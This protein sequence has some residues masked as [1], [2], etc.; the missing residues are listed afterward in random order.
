MGVWEVL[1][2]KRKGVESLYLVLG[3]E[4]RTSIGVWYGV[5]TYNMQYHKVFD[6]LTGLKLLFFSSIVQFSL[7]RSQ[8]NNLGLKMKTILEGG[9]GNADSLYVTANCQ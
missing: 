7:R 1:K 6:F 9:T 5:I 2:S 8:I 3:S 4:G